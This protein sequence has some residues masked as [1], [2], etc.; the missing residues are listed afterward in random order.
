[1]KN[2]YYIYL[3]IASIL[4]IIIAIWSFT[5]DRQTSTLEKIT[6]GEVTH[7]VFYAPMYVAIENGYFE[8][9]GIDIEL[10]LTSGAD[11]VSAAV[12]SGDVEVGFAGAESAIYIYEKGEK[13]YLQI[14]SGLTKRDGQFILSRTKIDNFELED[15]YGKEIL[16][17]RSSG[18][19]ALNFLNALKN[20]NIDPKKININYSVDFAA[21]SGTFI[22]DTGDFVNLFEPNALRLEQEGYAYVV[23]SIGKLSGEMPYTAFYARKS[24]IKEN[25]NT[26][27]SFAQAINKGL[28]FTHNNSADKIAEVILN[29]FPDTSLNDLTKLI[30]RYKENDSWLQTTYISEK[31]LE[32]L[33]DIMIDNNLLDKYVPY[34]DLVI[35]YD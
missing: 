2:K 13:D 19:P 8:E 23:E 15:L 34:K 21:L 17:G 24:Y 20:E 26:I 7:S 30:A 4:I 5:K 11:K 1:M 22:G 32:N 25:E 9:E 6:I 27:K 18:M 12:L 35:N 16:V 28:K 10:V 29:Q 3:V 33:E 31:L 14:F